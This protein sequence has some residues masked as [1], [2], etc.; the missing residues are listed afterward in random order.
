MLIEIS[1]G[2]LT[3]VLMG[4]LTKLRQNKS[5]SLKVPLACIKIPLNLS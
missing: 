2:F 3:G 4:Q 1:A 5:W